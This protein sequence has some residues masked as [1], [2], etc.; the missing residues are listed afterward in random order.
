MPGAFT[1]ESESD[2]YFPHLFRCSSE[3]VNALTIS[4]FVLSLLTN[5]SAVVVVG[6]AFVNRSMISSRRV[7]GASYNNNYVI[8]SGLRSDGLAAA[9]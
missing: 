2:S 8:F 5:A 3:E 9:K 1:I 4:A 7:R 6:K